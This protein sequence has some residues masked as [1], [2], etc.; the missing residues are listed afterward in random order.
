MVSKKGSNQHTRKAGQHERRRTM[1]EWNVI[2]RN[3]WTREERIADTTTN[4]IEADR[5]A[6]RILLDLP[7]YVAWRLI[8]IHAPRVGSDSGGTKEGKE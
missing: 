3:I 7:N 4:A 6:L 8:S 1:A 5:I 2:K